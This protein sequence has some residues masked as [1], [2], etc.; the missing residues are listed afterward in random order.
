[1]AKGIKAGNRAKL[2]AA[3]R[4]RNM[5]QTADDSGLGAIQGAVTTGPSHSC[6][7]IQ[8]APQIT[9]RSPTAGSHCCSVHSTPPLRSIG[10][11]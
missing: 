8:L 9:P 10:S 5:A 4:K 1:M 2:K 11:C 3:E 6:D 7:E